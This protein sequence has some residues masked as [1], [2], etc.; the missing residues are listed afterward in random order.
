MI[1]STKRPIK[2]KIELSTIEMTFQDV[3]NLGTLDGFGTCALI[4]WQIDLVREI[5][6]LG[7]RN[8]LLKW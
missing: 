3:T 2:C 8:M 1:V 5:Y 7:N 4:K 6:W